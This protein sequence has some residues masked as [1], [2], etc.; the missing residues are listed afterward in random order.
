MS[1]IL[2][3]LMWVSH[4]YSLKEATHKSINENIAGRTVNEFSL[5]D[6][7]MNHLGFKAGV[8]EP[9]HGY[10]EFYRQYV[11]QRI[12]NWLGEGGFQEDRPGEWYDYF[13]N[14]PTRSVNHFHNPLKHWS[15]A[16]LN[17]ILGLYSGQSS[18]LWSQNPN[19]HIG[20]KWSWKDARDYFYAGLTSSK[21]ADREMNFSNMFRA[22]GQLMHLVHDSSVPEHTRND[23]HALPAYEAYV[24]NVRNANSTLWRSW[25]NGSPPFDKSILNVPTVPLAPVPISR[26]IDTDRYTGMNPEVTIDSRIGLAEYTNANFLSRD[27]MFTD[28]LN[29]TNRHYFPYPKGSNAILWTDSSNNRRYLRKTGDGEPISHLTVASILY[30]DRL[31]Y[32]PQYNRALPVGLDDKCYQEY[33]YKLIPRAV[34]YSAGLLDY[35]FRGDID[36]VPDDATGSGYVIVNNSNEDMN[37]TFELFYDKT[38]DERVKLTVPILSTPIT[39]GK[40]SSG[41]NKSP[42]ITFSAPTDAKEPGK[43]MLVFKGNLGNETDSVV[44][45]V[46]ELPN[47]SFIFLIASPTS[48]AVWEITEGGTLKPYSFNIASFANKYTKPAGIDD[49]Y[50][51]VTQSNLKLNKHVYTVETKRI[52][53][54]LSTSLQY[55]RVKWYGWPETRVMFGL[56]NCFQPVDYN[57]ASEDIWDSDMTY[58][59]KG[60]LCSSRHSSQRDFS[61]S[62]G[63]FWNKNMEFYGENTTG[64]IEFDRIDEH[65]NQTPQEFYSQNSVFAVISQSKI[66]KKDNFYTNE[67]WDTRDP[68][69]WIASPYGCCWPPTQMPMLISTKDNEFYNLWGYKIYFGDVFIGMMG[70]NSVSTERFTVSTC[71][72]GAEFPAAALTT[73]ITTQDSTGNST[74]FH[75][76][77]Y[78]NIVEIDGKTD[79]VTGDETF[80]CFTAHKSNILT[81]RESNSRG[82]VFYKH[83]NEGIARTYNLIY[84]IN[85]GGLI[86]IPIATLMDGAYQYSVSP[87]SIC[88]TTVNSTEIYGFQG[89]RASNISSKIADSKIIYTYT[90]EQWTGPLLIQDW[91]YTAANTGNWTFIK[92]IIGIIDIATGIKNEY[93]IT[94]EF[95]GMNL[96]HFDKT[97]AAAIGIHI[98]K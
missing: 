7:L 73:L 42:N 87:V 28:D 21:T 92:R 85:G 83:L 84:R 54:S 14:R 97:T 10:S 11:N 41:N 30:N 23:A 48:Y 98:A 36:M 71:P 91:Y 25:I 79:G 96:S 72:N 13:L 38:T 82:H 67:S 31:K 69:S 62:L 32:F 88:D 44:G 94:D 86:T 53:A 77:D 2:I 90:I 27:T 37:G 52:D 93:E 6:Y 33:A 40:K 20:G 61:D 18:V 70:T 46:I 3:S 68:N 75:I 95:L 26:I 35:F 50:P 65:I 80:V 49:L 22:V 45:K 89:Q 19:Q 58:T 59:S 55:G 51:S 74:E 9:L 24:E 56:R 12:E 60:Y 39:I 63:A 15:E 81:V 57:P 4:G 78:D 76:L 29:S 66:I 34:G 8:K 64:R 5:N 47:K 1:L 16:G 17:D 43:Y